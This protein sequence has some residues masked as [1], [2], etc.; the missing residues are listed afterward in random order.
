MDRW[1]KYPSVQFSVSLSLFPFRA[2]PVKKK[3]QSK[4]LDDDEAS[5]KDIDVQYNPD[6]LANLLKDLQAHTNSKCA[7]IERDADFMIASMQQA[8]NL[9]MIKL[10]TQVKQMSVRRFKEE[11]GCSLEAVTRGAMAGHDRSLMDKGLMTPAG[12]K[13]NYSHARNPR[14]GE[15][16]LSMNGSPLG[17]FSTVKKVRPT[18]HDIVPPTPMVTLKNGDVLDLEEVD[19]EELSEETKADAL[20][21]MVAV[22]D[23]MRSLMDKL[24]AKPVV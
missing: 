15:V 2:M 21:Q 3:V 16:I 10:P 8:F 19:V 7:Q 24:K 23:N 18:G 5:M 11:F 9:E 13:V 1:P 14:E 12:K 4:R 6:I 22:M 20:Q 17:S